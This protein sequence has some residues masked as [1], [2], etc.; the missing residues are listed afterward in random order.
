[1]QNTQG[2]WYYYSSEFVLPLYAMFKF[3]RFPDGVRKVILAPC[4]LY[5]P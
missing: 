5:H 4:M 1:M 3:L 2:V